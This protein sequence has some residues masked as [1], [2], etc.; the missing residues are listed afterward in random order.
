MKERLRAP[1]TAHLDGEANFATLLDNKKH[2]LAKIQLTGEI[3]SHHQKEM[4]NYMAASPQLYEAVEA[5]DTLCAVL[6]ISSLT[7]QARLAVR[8]TWPLVQIARAAARPGTAY[9]EAV[10][11]GHRFEIER[12]D[13]IIAGKDAEILRLRAELQEA[14]ARYTG[15]M[16]PDCYYA[17]TCGHD[18]GGCGGCKERRQ[19]VGGIY[20]GDQADTEKEG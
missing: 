6:N 7:P 3:H 11:K 9:A 8:E 4:F 18:P 1:W 15:P 14:Q 19:V 17:K 20:H 5:A 2:W 12:L 13:W 10:D 16:D